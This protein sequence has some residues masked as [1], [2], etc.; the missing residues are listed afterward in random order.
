MM[1]LISLIFSN[2]N[3]VDYIGL[4]MKNELKRITRSRRDVKIFFILIFILKIQNG[5]FSRVKH[6]LSLFPNE[7]QCGVK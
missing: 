3:E 6:V 2:L 7:M 4:T 5:T 1:P